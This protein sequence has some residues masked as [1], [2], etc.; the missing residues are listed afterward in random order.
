LKNRFH[1]VWYSTQNTKHQNAK[2]HDV[3][4]G[5]KTCIGIR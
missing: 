4:F 3:V 1:Q 2:A 5:L